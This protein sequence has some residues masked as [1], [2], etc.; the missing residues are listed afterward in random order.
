MGEIFDL[1]NAITEDNSTKEI[2]EKLQGVLN[3]C[4]A[5]MDRVDGE[6]VN[7][8]FVSCKDIKLIIKALGGK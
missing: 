8:H 7:L 3:E 1:P 2:I 4:P 6:S 5:E